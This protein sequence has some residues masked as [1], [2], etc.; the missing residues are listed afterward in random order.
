MAFGGGGLA[1]VA[2][3]AFE[4]DTGEASRDVERFERRYRDSA[5]ELAGHVVQECIGPPTEL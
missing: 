1:G 3:V 5:G 2:R 4:A